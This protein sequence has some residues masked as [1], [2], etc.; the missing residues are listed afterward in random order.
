M[1]PETKW[2]KQCDAFAITHPPS[3]LIFI[4]VY[5]DG[6]A[7][8]LRREAYRYRGMV[9][10]LGR[11][12]AKIEVNYIRMT[13]ARMWLEIARWRSGEGFHTPKCV[14]GPR[15]CHP[16]TTEGKRWTP[17]CDSKS[18]FVCIIHLVSFDEELLGMRNTKQ[19]AVF[20]YAG[21]HSLR[22]LYGW[23]QRF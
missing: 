12:C 22:V 5:A 3:N 21:S 20:Q 13:M 8:G 11:F 4:T 7:A 16:Q 10:I 2:G 14:N 9:I 23:V 18:I 1:T 17:W 19:M 6:K 15:R